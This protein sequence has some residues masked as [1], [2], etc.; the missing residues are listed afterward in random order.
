MS[1]DIITKSSS[2]GFAWLV[3]NLAERHLGVL[4]DNKPNMSQQCATA[5]TKAN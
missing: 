3:S 4:V 1:W 5:A 2:A